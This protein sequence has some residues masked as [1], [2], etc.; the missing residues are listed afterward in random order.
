MIV[1]E[2]IQ[3]IVLGLVGLKIVWNLL[4][5]YA[6][7]WQLLKPGAQRSDSVSMMQYLEIGLVCIAVLVA[8]IIPGSQW[9][10]SAGKVAL[11][12]FGSIAASWIHFFVIGMLGGALASAIDR[13]R[14]LHK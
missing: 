9:F 2:I 6:L 11:I 3:I 8:A 7:A 14:D 13:R 10:Q 12:C 1:L 4:V 5:P